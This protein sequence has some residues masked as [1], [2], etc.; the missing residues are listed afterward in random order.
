MPERFWQKVRV[1]GPNEC[2]PWI[3]GTG[4]FGHGTFMVDGKRRKW[5]P[6][7]QIAFELHHGR[8]VTPGL[9]VLHDCDNPPCCNPAH[10]YEGTQAQNMR[11]RSA[12]GRTARGER[13]GTAKLTEAQVLAIRAADLSLTQTELAHQFGVSRSLIGAILRREGW[14]HC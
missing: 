1:G 14:R 13:M 2:W 6:A 7:H 12:R 11:D 3:G 8:P 10:L 9:F 4:H 5:R